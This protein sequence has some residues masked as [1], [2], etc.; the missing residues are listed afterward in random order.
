MNIDL[1]KKPFC[2]NDSQ[3]AWVRDTLA[4]MTG[5]EKIGQL[6]LPIAFSSDENYLRYEMLRYHVGGLLFKTSPSREVRKAL[7]FMQ[8][9][10]TELKQLKKRKAMLET[11][12]VL[13]ASMTEEG[14]YDMT[15]LT[16]S[17]IFIEKSDL[18]D[19]NKVDEMWAKFLKYSSNEQEED[20][21]YKHKTS[22]GKKASAKIFVKNKSMLGCGC[23]VP[24]KS[25]SEHEQN[26]IIQG[27]NSGLVS[28]H[29]YAI[30][31]CFELPKARSKKKRK[32][33]RLM[34]IRNPWGFQEWQGKWC[35]DSEEIA[36]NKDRINEILEEKY[37]GTNEKPHVGEDNND[38]TFIMCYSDFRN[39]FNKVCVSISFPQGTLGVRFFQDGLLLNQVVTC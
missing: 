39:I 33:S 32:C 35:D 9:N 10:S 5:D 29:A 30:L 20:S 8:E 17:K 26:V 19:E 11:D 12:P 1:T 3:I 7:Q 38:G 21:D 15:G 36:A 2:L 28:G 22:S 4:S 14:I 6:F 18:R 34:R 37:R 16:P 24:R 27:W 31:D 13:G 25:G 23:D